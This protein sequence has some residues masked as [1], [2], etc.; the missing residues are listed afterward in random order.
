M[1]LCLRAEDETDRD[2]DALVAHQWREQFRGLSPEVAK[3]KRWKSG[4]WWNW[5]NE[6]VLTADD[7]YAEGVHP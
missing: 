6:L 3:K 2:F 7:I 5:Y 1:F 4:C